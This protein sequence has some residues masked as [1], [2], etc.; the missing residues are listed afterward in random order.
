MLNSILDR[1][2][3]TTRNGSTKKGMP[4]ESILGLLLFIIYTNN[5]MLNIH[6][7]GASI[8]V[9]DTTFLIKRKETVM[10]RLAQV[11]LEDTN[12]WFCYKYSSTKYQQ[13]PTN[14]GKVT[15]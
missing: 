4:Q 11:V 12:T 1:E 2:N 9:D 15:F 10:K 13:N 3:I 5:L 7:Y 6:V 14:R 8:Y